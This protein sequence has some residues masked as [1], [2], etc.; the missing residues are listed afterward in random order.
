MAHEPDV[1]LSMNAFGSPANRKILPD[2]PLQS[3]A[4]RALLLTFATSHGLL[5]IMLY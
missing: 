5:A 4:L 3:T 2:I 1:A